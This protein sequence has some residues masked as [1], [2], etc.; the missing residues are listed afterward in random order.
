LPEFT[1][2]FIH[3]NFDI[4]LDGINGEGLKYIIGDKP[5]EM[6][7]TYLYYT[8][9]EANRE[10]EYLITTPKELIS[11]AVPNQKALEEGLKII[12]I[13]PDMPRTVSVARH[14]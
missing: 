6:L 5:Y 4:S 1:P 2:L 13:N 9:M 11:P 10:H 14:T 12:T 7:R 3:K 8:F